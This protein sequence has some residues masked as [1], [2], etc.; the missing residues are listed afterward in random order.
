MHPGPDPAIEAERLLAALATPQVQGRLREMVGH[1]VLHDL[2]GQYRHGFNI[3]QIDHLSAS[4]ES[5]RYAQAH[6][7]GAARFRDADELLRAALTAAP[8]AGLVLEFGVW[9]GRTVNLIAGLRP[10]AIVHGFDSFEGLPEAW[11]PGFGAGMFR[12][13]ALPEVAPN[14]RLEVGLF[15]RTLP[16][17]LD[18]IGPAPVAF[19]HIDCDLYASTQTVLAQLRGRIVPGTVILFD[20]YFNYPGWQRHEHRAFQEFILEQG[21]RYAY[22]GVVPHVEQVAVR[23]LG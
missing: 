14:V 1:F 20:E 17:F 13:E 7:R 10:D 18:R 22:I 9:K 6:M 12:T 5:A 19:L 11:R 3:D 16:G 2:F 8:A 21:L 23:I 15:D 4:L